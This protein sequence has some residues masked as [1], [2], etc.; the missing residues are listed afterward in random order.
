MFYLFVIFYEEPALEKCF[1]ATYK[2]YCQHVPRWM[3]RLTPWR[4]EN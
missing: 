3:P 2:E 1:G 4:T